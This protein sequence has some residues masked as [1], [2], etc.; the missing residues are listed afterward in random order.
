MSMLQPSATPI[1]ADASDA[2]LARRVAAR[3]ADAI[4]LLM[5]RH[6]QRLFRTARAILRDD[7]EAEDAVQEGYIKA[8]DAIGGFRSESRLSTWL[9]RIV[10]NEALGR[11]RAVRRGAEVIRLEAD[12]DENVERAPEPADE[13]PGP[14]SEAM[15]AQARRIIESKIDRLPDPYRAV[16]VMR[17]V[18]EMTVEETAEA[19]GIPDATVRSRLF[20]ARAMLRESL[21]R[22]M[23]RALDDAFGFAGERC[24]RITERV[25]AR[26]AQHPPAGP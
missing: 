11:L 22:S 4:R 26:L 25:L 21:A 2:E 3:E 15:H 8:I 6:N 1:P 23:D 19:L 14:E 9:V 13:R 16:F 20:R 5:R 7:A 12:L 24:D 10:A 17:A 18:E